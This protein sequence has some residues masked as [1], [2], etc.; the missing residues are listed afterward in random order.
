[1]KKIL[2]PLLLLFS[3][4]VFSQTGVGWTPYRTKA[5]FRDSTY[6]Y[7]DA[8]FNGTV[9]VA[10][11]A[12]KIG[13][14]T[15]TANGAE[16]NIL[17]GVLATSAEIN[18]LVGVTSNVQTQLNAK[19]STSSLSSYAPLANPNF[20][21]AVRLASDSLM[22]KTRLRAIVHDTIQDR[23]DNAYSLGD[24]AFLK[25]LANTAG[26]AVT[27]EYLQSYGGGGGGGGSIGMYE[28]RG[29]V[30][31]TT[32]IPTN[33]DS[34]VINTGFVSHP[35]LL[36]YR[37]GV[38]QWYNSGL[39][40]NTGTITGA[41]VFNQSTGTVIV[42]PVFSTGEKLVVHAFDPIV[43][44]NLIPEGGSGG[45]GGG[46]GSSLLTNLAAYFKLDEPSGYLIT[47][48]V[49]NVDYA[50]QSGT[51]NQ[52]GILGKAVALDGTTQGIET[53]YYSEIQP[54]GAFT[55]SCWINL[56][57]L[58]SVK[59]NDYYVFGTPRG[60]V[61]YNPHNI[62]IRQ[63]DNKVVF[64]VS[65]T[66]TPEPDEFTVVSSGALTIGTWYH[67][68]GVCSGTGSALKL[69]IGAAGSAITD[70]STSAESP[71]GTIYNS[72]SGGLSF[73]NNFDGGLH[74]LDGLFDEPCIWIGRALSSG[75]ITTLHGPSNNG[76]SYPFN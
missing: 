50:V 70:V 36:V 49:G 59:V 9:R 73:G 4:P 28:L 11:G 12:V 25:S 68:V 31:T 39:T 47:D 33:G 57:V 13:A 14:V 46:G 22:T 58:P 60:A 66:T 45:G 52:T 8:R 24:L 56:D 62:Q 37:N 76:I 65:N 51:P 23:L 2:I 7:K 10:E 27:L 6:F 3:I 16:I 48:E 29:I 20:T 53:N 30:G 32:G 21:T 1:M 69:Y 43:W 40:N 35:H 74:S 75:D 42:R 64:T 54:A 63:S 71:T 44:T 19:A 34:L 38:M 26:N 55:V 5:N 41:Y 61:P 67:I 17:D 15:I 18:Y 72:T